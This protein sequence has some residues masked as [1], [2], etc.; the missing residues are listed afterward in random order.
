L[1]AETR[2]DFV[3][4]ISTHALLFSL[5]LDVF[6]NIIVIFLVFFAIVIVIGPKLT[7]EILSVLFATRTWHCFVFATLRSFD[8]NFESISLIVVELV[9]L[10]HRILVFITF[11]I[12]LARTLDIFKIIEI[13]V[14][15][16]IIRSSLLLIESG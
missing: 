13:V 2:L 6:F 16:I 9:K 8:F 12:R 3:V 15:I 4:I 7:A 1:V 5:G 11:L 14:V 10:F